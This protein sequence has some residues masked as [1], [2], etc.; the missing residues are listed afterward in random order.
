MSKQ[1]GDIVGQVR[2]AVPAKGLAI[3]L[4]QQL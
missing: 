1:P 4:D 3:S 2:T